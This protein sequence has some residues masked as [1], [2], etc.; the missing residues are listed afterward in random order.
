[1]TDKTVKIYDKPA[2]NHSKQISLQFTESVPFQNRISTWIFT[3]STQF[4]FSFLY[5]TY[6]AFVLRPHRTCTQY[7][8]N[9]HSVHTESTLSTHRI[10]TQYTQN[11]YSVHTESVLT[12][13]RICTQFTQNLYSVHRESVL[14]LLSLYLAKT[15]LFSC[16][17]ST[18][19]TQQTNTT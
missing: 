14:S 6:K 15:N 19:T 10:Y 8:Q 13:H 9:L 4:L 3:L 2:F 7:T 17:T 18:N 5:S 11:L 16:R 1:M 12:T